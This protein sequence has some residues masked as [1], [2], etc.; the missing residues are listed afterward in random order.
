MSPKKNKKSLKLAVPEISGSLKP[1]LEL[2]HIK[3]TVKSFIQRKKVEE[4][5]AH[6][7]ACKYGFTVRD[8]EILGKI[9]MILKL[10]TKITDIMIMYNTL[11]EENQKIYRGLI[12]KGNQEIYRGLISEGMNLPQIQ[13]GGGPKIF[14]QIALP[15]LIMAVCFTFLIATSNELFVMIGNTETYT[16]NMGDLVA[17]QVKDSIKGTGEYFFN[18]DGF[19]QAEHNALIRGQDTS[20]FEEMMAKVDLATD[21]PSNSQVA[22][23]NENFNTVAEAYYEQLQ[24]GFLGILALATGNVDLNGATDLVRHDVTRELAVKQAGDSITAQLK[25][26]G[27]PMLNEYKK[28]IEEGWESYTWKRQR[29]IDPDRLPA[30]SEQLAKQRDLKDAAISRIDNANN[31]YGFGEKPF[32]NE[33]TEY[34]KYQTKPDGTKGWETKV[35]DSK[36]EV[37]EKVEKMGK[38]LELWGERVH[39][40]ATWAV[41]GLMAGAWA[42]TSVVMSAA[43]GRSKRTKK[44]KKK[45]A[46][47]K[48]GVTKKKGATKKKAPAK[49]KGATKKKGSKKKKGF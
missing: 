11:V 28:Y 4:T 14:N 27:N 9:A 42:A 2:S 20:I 38:D 35:Y 44:G 6:C 25:E 10:H 37:S 33:R 39:G 41:G 15:L 3:S 36:L 47:K 1:L 16:D 31:K 18:Q 26:Y 21:V 17:S 12:S 34:S 49:K 32:S 7:I 8:T 13:Q 22:T 19:S 30:S 5:N 43:R 24:S 23:F 45:G 48:K 40:M 29:K 46:T